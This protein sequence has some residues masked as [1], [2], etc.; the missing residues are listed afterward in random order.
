[1]NTL[2]WSG[3]IQTV[4]MVDLVRPNNPGDDVTQAFTGLVSDAVWTGSVDGGRI[5]G[6]T[7]SD[8]VFLDDDAF[9]TP[10]LEN[11]V[12]FNMRGGDDVVDLTS[13]RFSY[14][15]ARLEGGTGNDWLFGGAVGDRILGGAGEDRLKGGAGN[16]VINSGS[17]QDHLFGGA[18]RDKF[19]FGDHDGRD[20]I[21]DFTTAGKGHDVIDLSSSTIITDFADLIANH[22][23]VEDGE[24]KL[25]LDDGSY[26]R[27][28][29]VDPLDLIEQDFLF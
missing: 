16:D 28:Y 20:N 14:G 2:Q 23:I 4:T 15:H 6:T 25:T 24:L 10:R 8:L 7:G 1:M 12:V 21:Y 27:L 5:V 11:I 18:G 19:I 22:S 9:T 29:G 3:T 26:I 13:D 17:E